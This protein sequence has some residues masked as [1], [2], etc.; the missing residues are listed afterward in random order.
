MRPKAHPLTCRIYPVFLIICYLEVLLWTSCLVASC[1]APVP[2]ID[3]HSY[4]L[5]E[6]GNL[7]FATR[8]DVPAFASLPHVRHPKLLW[9]IEHQA[10]CSSLGQA[11]NCCP[12]VDHRGGLT[13]GLCG[14]PAATG[15]PAPYAGVKAIS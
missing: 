6:T 9:R 5:R 15:L 14:F 2:A 13:Q 8:G 4:L 10:A 11:L 12:R 1:A 3:G 7:K